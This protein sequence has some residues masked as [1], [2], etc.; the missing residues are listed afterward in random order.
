MSSEN[1]KLAVGI[2]EINLATPKSAGIYF[3][4]VNTTNQIKN[5]KLVLV[6]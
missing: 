3:V 4:T 6:D 2:N 5:A 1:I